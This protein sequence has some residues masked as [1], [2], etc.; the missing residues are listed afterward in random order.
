[1]YRNKNFEV[2]NFVYDI[3]I[4]SVIVKQ[5][6]LSHL[7]FQGITS[8][9]CKKAQ[10]NNGQCLGQFLEFSRHFKSDFSQISFS[11]SL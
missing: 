9:V 1:M 5:V 4:Y 11:E 3:H 8:H 7:T 2:K 6:Q 10:I